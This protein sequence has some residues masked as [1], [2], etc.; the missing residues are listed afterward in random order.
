MEPVGNILGKT[1]DVEGPHWVF[2]FANGLVVHT[3]P[4]MRRDPARVLPVG[5]PQDMIMNR[6]VRWPDI[7]AGKRVLDIFA[8]SGILG[9]MALRLDAASVDF[10]DINPRAV[11]FVTENCAR[12][13]F[14]PE[15]RRA[16]EGSISDYVASRP[17][18][19]VLANPPFVVTPPGIAGT[20]TS[21]A[22]ADGNVLTDILMTRLDALLAPEGEAY[23]FV[24]QLVVDGEPLI[25]RTLPGRLL[26]RAVA[27]T[28]VQEVVCPL[29]CYVAAYLDRFAQHASAVREWEGDLRARLG[30]D[31]GVQH[32]IMRIMPRG[33]AP[34]HWS[35]VDNLES[36]HGA[37]F[38]Y[39]AA[40][41]ADMA[42][43]RVMENLI[44][45]GSD[46]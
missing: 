42:L 23:I 12:N 37:G 5:G 6:L 9:L 32:Y 14:A 11:R 17:Y 4:F 1:W 40:S 13:G 19:L 20:L 27:F 22:G 18:D 15:R 43:G 25:A 8:G 31:L 7:V 38:R 39:P 2:R 26:Q 30:R 10:V 46:V 34:T 35:V 44:L 21:N 24:L 45:P 29:D 3:D 33:D 36:D 28:A 16:I 41:Q